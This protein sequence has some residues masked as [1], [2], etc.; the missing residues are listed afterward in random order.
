MK[1]KFKSAKNFFAA[2]ACLSMLLTVFVGCGPLAG[3]KSNEKKL[4]EF[5]FEKKLNPGLSADVSGNI[6][7]NDHSV[8]LNV[9][10]SMDKTKLKAS[11]TVSPKAHVLVGSMKLVSGITA[12]DFSNKD[13]VKLIVTAENG[14]TQV[15]TVKVNTVSE[16][17]KSE[18]G[19]IKSLVIPKNLVIRKNPVI[20]KNLSILNS[21]LKRKFLHLVLEKM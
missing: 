6:V 18:G 14:T 16:T 10:S 17:Q 15:Y 4:T 5:K 7:E 9:P 12:I 19:G 3:Q 20:R 2:A 8:T 11:F 21:L 1:T 13:G